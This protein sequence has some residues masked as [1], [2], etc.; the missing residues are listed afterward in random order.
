MQHTLF[1]TRS[2]TPALLYYSRPP[3]L[4][5]CPPALSPSWTSPS[6][7]PALMYPRPHVPLSCT[8]G[9]LYYSRPPVM[10]LFSRVPC[11]PPFYIP[12]S[13]TPALVYCRGV[14][15]PPSCSTPSL[16]PPALAG[17]VASKAGPAAADNNIILI[18]ARWGR[19][20]RSASEGTT[21]C[22]LS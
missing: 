14:A 6:C 15:V 1:G 22:I 16:R 8:P 11:I 7:T 2:C 12:P 19:L 13:C 21:A 4:Y 5:S 10:T 9:P 17:W 3:V 18:P 20:R